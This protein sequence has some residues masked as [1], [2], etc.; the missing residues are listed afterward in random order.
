MNPIK[1]IYT[2]LPENLD[3]ADPLV[4]YAHQFARSLSLPIH[5]I[6]DTT[7][8][9]DDRW[10]NL[11]AGK[12]FDDIEL[13]FTKVCKPLGHE[14]ID[15]IGANTASLVLF[16]GFTRF[17]FL[18]HTSLTSLHKLMEHLSAPLVEVQFPQW[19]VKEIMIASG[20][21]PYSIRLEKF[22]VWLAKQWGARI[23][24]LHVISPITFL[25]KFAIEIR[26]NWQDF[27]H[28]DFTQSVHLRSA[29]KYGEEQGVEIR[30]MIK[31]GQVR[32]LIE[33]TLKEQDYQLLAMGSNYSSH[34]L[35]RLYRAD[36]T[37]LI[38]PSANC[39]LLT[40]RGAEDETY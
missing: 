4:D 26:E 10:E 16:S 30:V 28:L 33:E 20:A 35:R 39:P 19:P 27:L 6:L 22:V 29:L 32:E 2:L 37:A 25:H 8:R 11:I 34:S 12:S 23:T 40:M 13:I 38:S 14:I 18:K 17:A 24:L 31:H 5:F 7:K 36:M 1:Q 15:I 3:E 9:E 21:L